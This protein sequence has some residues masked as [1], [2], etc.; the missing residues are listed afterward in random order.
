M[1]Q[2]AIKEDKSFW[3]IVGVFIALWGVVE[4]N[5]GALWV[6]TGER[7]FPLFLVTVG[8]N[9]AVKTIWGSL[10]QGSV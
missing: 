1:K 6:L 10:K 2:M 7:L 5:G 4:L 9:I 8:L 3:A